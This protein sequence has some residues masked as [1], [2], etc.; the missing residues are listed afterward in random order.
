MI[1]NQGAAVGVSCL[2]GCGGLGGVEGSVLY[3][4]SGYECRILS[5]Q[6]SKDSLRSA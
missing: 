1:E 6:F 2:L 4:V 5:P 3:A